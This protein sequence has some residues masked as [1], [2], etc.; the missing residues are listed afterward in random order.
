MA[1]TQE[2][3]SKEL[4]EKKKF[5]QNWSRIL[6]LT[7]NE[8]PEKP[9]KF[10][11]NEVA[12]LFKEF[13]EERMKAAREEFKSDLKLIMEGK[14]ALD[15]TLKEKRSQLAKQEEEEYKKING[16]LANA[17]RKLEGKQQE[18]KELADAG[19]GEFV[20]EKDEETTE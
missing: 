20:E 19:A 9:V 15:K 1:D 7:E 2:Q 18:N 14:L 4:K 11:N 3:G 6:K 10:A 16:L 17:L 13:S 12:N 8:M 5:E